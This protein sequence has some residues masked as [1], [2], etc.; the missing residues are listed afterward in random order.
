MIKETLFGPP[1]TGKTTELMNRL[2]TAMETVPPHKIAFVSF[3]RKGTYEGV[4]RATKRF[5][6]SDHQ[7]RYFRTLHSLC[8]RAMG[9]NRSDMIT[10]THYRTLSQATGISFTGYFT[11]DFNSVND[12]YLHA[13][14]MEKQNPALA[15]EIFLHLDAQKYKYIK[16]QYDAMKEQLG[17]LDFDDLLLQYIDKGQPLN[18]EVVFIDEAQD[19]T[20]LQW[21]AAAK[22]FCNA[23][24]VCIAGDDD[25]AVYEWSGADVLRFLKFSKKQTVLTKS[26]RLPKAV[27]NLAA[28]VSKDIFRRKKKLFK[29]SGKKGTVRSENNLKNVEFHGGELVLA[30]TNHLL[31][32]MSFWAADQGLP[33]KIKGKLSIDKFTLNAIKKYND[34]VAGELEKDQLAKHASFFSRITPDVP[35]QQAIK[36]KKHEIAYYE[37]VLRNGVEKQEP[38]VFETFHS[39]KGSENDHVVLCTDLT[40]RVLKAYDKNQDS[41]LRCLYVGMTRTK[42]KLTVLSPESDKAYPGKYFS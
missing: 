7:K 35:W 30:R 22:M 6:L 11:E 33:F 23:K 13:V 26:Y 38:I 18:A 29:P 19:L 27:L 5:K 1:G 36:L 2:M 8:F 24:Y 25:Q 41:E 39:S 20:P 34:M 12:E 9:M 3:T 32:K 21:R 15:A 10:Q 4:E 17:I 37:N 14:A 31:R 40:D 42:N 16:F 28:R